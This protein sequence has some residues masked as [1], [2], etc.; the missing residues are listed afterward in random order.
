MQNANQKS[1]IKSENQIFKTKM[2]S[3]RSNLRMRNAECKKPNLNAG[4]KAR[5]QFALK[6]TTSFLS[7][8]IIII[9]LRCKGICLA[10]GYIYI[11]IYF[12][13]IKIL[14]KSPPLWRALEADT[15]LHV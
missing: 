1:K 7:K 13:K 6:I 8:E 4:L 9:F 15:I 3:K 10:F 12:V 11:S 2:Q 14:K 5:K